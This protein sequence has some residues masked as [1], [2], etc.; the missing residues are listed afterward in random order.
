M[1]ED[2][3]PLARGW[4]WAAVIAGVGLL[5]PGAM[6]AFGYCLAVFAFSDM[7]YG[8]LAVTWPLAVFTLALLTVGAGGAALWHG[9]A[10]LSGKPSRP[11]RLPPIWGLVGVFGLCVALGYMVT[12]TALAPALFFPLV[13]LAAA[14]LPPLWAAAWFTRGEAGMLTYR[15]GVL[16]FA[17]GATLGVAVALL[18]EFGLPGLLFALVDNLAGPALAALERLL[19]ALAGRDIARA[20]TGW[21]FVYAFVQLAVIAPLA[22]E[23]AKPL[24]TLPLLRSLSRRT[25]FLVGALAGAGFAALENV[26]YAASGYDFWIG[27]LVVRAL[28]GAIHPLGAGLMALAWRDVLRG[29]PG[30]GRAWLRRFGLAAGMHALWNGGSLLVIT[31]AGA[32]FF[33][34]LPP[35]LDVLGLSMGGTVLALLIVL[36]IAALWL[37]RVLAAQGAATEEAVAPDAR[38]VLSDRA[39][40]LWAV[41]CLVAFVPLGIAGLRLVLR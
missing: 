26:I 13:L 24:V 35:E 39:A 31:L 33:G 36:G 3:T 16:A 34:S 12:A 14:A 29:E 41:A 22:E 27:I 15:R 17:G 37:G 18:L 6:L 30:A 5:F 9:T 28:G 2:L 32:Q 21:G 4:K 40:A 8:S 23:L 10:S 7:Y 1:E 38:Y 11:L 20:L 25:A 19:Q